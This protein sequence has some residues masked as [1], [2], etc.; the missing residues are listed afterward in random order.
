MTLKVTYDIPYGNSF[1]QRVDL[2]VP[3]IS[4]SGVIFWFHGGNWLEGSK[5]ASGYDTGSFAYNSNNDNFAQSLALGGFVVVN[6]NTRLVSNSSEGWGGMADGVYPNNVNDVETILQFATQAAAGDNFSEHWKTIYDLVK[7]HGYVVAGFDTGGY[8]AVMG[9]ANYGTSANIWPKGIIN[10]CGPMDLYTN[11]PFAG[12]STNPVNA[13]YNSQ[14]LDRYLPNDS[15]VRQAASPR[16]RYTSTWSTALTAST[17]KIVNYVNTNDQLVPSTMILPF[18]NSLPSARRHLISF[19]EG[20]TTALSHNITTGL[21]EPLINICSSLFLNSAL[22]T[23]PNQNTL[24]SLG[25]LPQFDPPD[26]TNVEVLVVAGGGAG[27]QDEGGGGG[28]GGVV[29]HP[30]YTFLAG[31]SIDIVVGEGGRRPLS[32]SSQGTGTAARGKNSSFGSIVALGGGGGGGSS[33]TRAAGAGG[34]GGGAGAGIT[35]GSGTLGQGFAG[36]STVSGIGGGGGGA[37]GPGLTTGQGGVGLQFS[38]SGTSV[39]YGGGGSGTS[40]LNANAAGGLGGGGT[41]TGFQ[42]ASNNGQDGRGGGG[43]AYSG[44]WGGAGNGGSG[45]VIVRYPAPQRATGGAVSVISGNVIHTFGSVGTYKF[46]TD[47]RNTFAETRVPPP[48]G[49]ICEPIGLSEYWGNDVYVRKGTVGFPRNARR[50]IPET[51][52]I[53]IINFYGASAG[54]YS[55][56]AKDEFGANLSLFNEDMIIRFDV[57]SVKESEEL[58]WSIEHVGVMPGTTTTTST[59]STTTTTMSMFDPKIR[60]ISGGIAGKFSTVTLNEITVS[61]IDGPA[62]DSFRYKIVGPAGSLT[63]GTGVFESTPDVLTA[64]GSAVLPARI[65]KIPGDYTYTFTFGNYTGTTSNGDRRYWVLTVTSGYELRVTAPTMVLRGR[66]I[67]VFVEGYPG[68]IINYTGQTSGDQQLSDPVSAFGNVTFDLTKGTVLPPMVY[69]WDFSGIKSIGTKIITVEVKSDAIP[70]TATVVSDNDRVSEGGIVRFTIMTTGLATNS[71]I[72]FKLEPVGTS[73]LTASDFDSINGIKPVTSLTN[74]YGITYSKKLTVDKTTIDVVIA[75]DSSVEET[76]S[77]RLR[78]YTTS[79]VSGASIDTSSSTVQIINTNVVVVTPV[80]PIPTEQAWELTADKTSVALNGGVLFT[81]TT[82][83]SSND[84]KTFNLRNTGT[85]KILYTNNSDSVSANFTTALV[86][87]KAIKIVSAVASV[88]GTVTV[89]AYDIT[90]NLRA[91]LVITISALTYNLITGTPSMNEFSDTIFEFETTDSDVGNN[92]YEITSNSSVVTLSPSTFGVSYYASLLKYRFLPIKATAGEVIQGLIGYGFQTVGSNYYPNIT[93]HL[94]SKG[95]GQGPMYHVNRNVF[96][97]GPPLTS[98]ARADGSNDGLAGTGSNWLDKDPTIKGTVFQLVGMHYGDYKTSLWI[99]VRRGQVMPNTP[100][101]LTV[102]LNNN[103][104]QAWTVFVPGRQG[105]GYELNNYLGVN[106]ID[107][108]IA[109]N[110]DTSHSSY[111]ATVAIQDGWL[112]L[113]SSG[114]YYVTGHLE[115]HSHRQDNPIGLEQA[116]KSLAPHTITIEAAPA[117]IPVGFR[118]TKAGSLKATGS[119]MVRNSDTT[120]APPVITSFSVTGSNFTFFWTTTGTVSSVEMQIVSGPSFGITYPSTVYRLNTALNNGSFAYT[121]RSGLVK[122]GTYV[123]RL[124]VYGPGGQTYTQTN[125]PGRVADVQFTNTDTVFETII[126]NG[127]VTPTASPYAGNLRFG[128]IEIG[129]EIDGTPYYASPGFSFANLAGVTRVVIKVKCDGSLTLNYDNVLI[130]EEV[131]YDSSWPN[132]MDGD[133]NM[134]NYALPTVGQVKN[135]TGTHSNESNIGAGACRVNYR[136]IVYTATS[137]WSS[138]SSTTP[139]DY[140]RFGGTFSGGP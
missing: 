66:P 39:Y 107:T 44:D 22:P 47:Y 1:R 89:G 12:A 42:A 99:G 37:G 59:T 24:P 68:D 106:I 119:I 79:D 61:I 91:S 90:N 56:V 51:G 34:S 81:L 36:V 8:L 122:N 49:P 97:Y 73:T 120:S 11:P 109:D 28:G 41:N 77:F 13:A 132:G 105:Q 134:I 93:V 138:S 7:T 86:D 135:I 50:V 69:S 62:G 10:M 102:Y 30:R 57:T 92:I 94:L 137:S 20:P 75:T 103:K 85:G 53:G 27:A 140:A 82:G 60:P 31:L 64:A 115:I 95:Y 139:S 117:D 108:N 128:Q 26:L 19:T 130:G 72:Y 127:T 32:A 123:M 65:F 78:V 126:V 52:Q 33:S 114:N 112:A 4:V 83:N 133:G 17:T 63:N 71:D 3:L 88:A 67:E 96:P 125:S 35:A 38:I 45:I 18:H 58:Y 9:A 84:L 54:N 111:A 15:V 100:T 40:Y 136:I 131:A 2:V 101:K 118:V 55:L 98:S 80:T 76:E 43:S 121:N 129:A 113:D 21:L 116:V 104:N 23:S 14:V 87:G 46:I 5:S 74:Q 110:P 124:I 29:Y 16:Y 48:E 25:T 70:I 6:C